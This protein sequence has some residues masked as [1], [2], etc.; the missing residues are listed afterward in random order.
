MNRKN[1]DE[2]LKG[3]ICEEND[4]NDFYFNWVEFK[5]K[6][7]KYSFMDLFEKFMNLS[8]NDQEV[9]VKGGKGILFFELV[10]KEGFE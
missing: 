10:N 2:K 4:A 7:N 3:T 9:V 5:S 8:L 1:W 6:D